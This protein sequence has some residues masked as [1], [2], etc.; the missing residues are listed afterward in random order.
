MTGMD[1]DFDA[2]RAKCLEELQRTKEAGR[3]A[4]HFIRKRAQAKKLAKSQPPKPK[5]SKKRRRN[6]KPKL[7]L[8]VGTYHE[9]IQSP[10]WAAKREKVFRIHGRKCCV[11]GSTNDLRVHHKTYKRLYRENPRDDLEVRCEGCHANEH[12]LDKGAIDPMTARYLSVM[13]NL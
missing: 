5:K 10:Q 11:C 4:Y 13:R 12:E 7:P 2:Y 8:F 6:R 1:T 3:K 9:Y